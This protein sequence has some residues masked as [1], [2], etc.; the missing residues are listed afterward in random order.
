[1][2]LEVVTSKLYSEA[3]VALA[4]SVLS[5][6][7]PARIAL[8]IKAIEFTIDNCFL[9]GRLYQYEGQVE[10]WNY[11][12]EPCTDSLCISSRDFLAQL[13]VFLKEGVFRMQSSPNNKQMFSLV[14]VL[15]LEEE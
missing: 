5:W 13:E 15:G 3:M 14:E 8:R 12:N 10:P 2:L 7:V 1:M 9:P 11:Q 6:R 4:L